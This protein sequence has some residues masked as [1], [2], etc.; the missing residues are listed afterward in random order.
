MRTLQAIIRRVDRQGETPLPGRG[1]PGSPAWLVKS[2]P[3]T[4]SATPRRV[5]SAFAGLDDVE[6]IAAIE[7]TA[8]NKARCR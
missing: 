6:Q 1:R 5:S 7:R 8:T 4:S 2:P 3:I